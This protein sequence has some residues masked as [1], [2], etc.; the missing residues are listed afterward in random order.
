[1][2]ITIK[3]SCTYFKSKHV[4]IR[5]ELHEQVYYA[6]TFKS[7]FT[8][9][10]WRHNTCYI[11]IDLFFAYLYIN[12]FVIVIRRSNASGKS[13][14]K[15]D[16]MLGLKDRKR[17]IFFFFFFAEV[18]RPAATASINQR[19]TSQ[20]LWS[21]KTGLLAFCWR[22]VSQTLFRTVCFVKVQ[23]I[24]GYKSRNMI[25]L[26]GLVSTFYHKLSLL[27][28]QDGFGRR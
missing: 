9:F 27:D 7:V 8:R 26:K 16:F 13:K 21:I 19:T 18:S 6:N 4:E 12:R 17:E 20:S 15:H 22:W 28:V 5:G 3:N 1:M 10:Q 24:F 23:V 14:K 25:V 11:N 2:D